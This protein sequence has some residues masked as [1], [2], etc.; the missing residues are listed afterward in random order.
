MV[1]VIWVLENIKRDN[2]FYK[3]FNT[4]LLFN[5]VIQWR[6]HN[7]NTNTVLLCDELTYEFLTKLNALNLW[8]E[9]KKMPWIKDIDKDVFWA[10]AKV[11][12]ISGIEAPSV[13]LDNDFIVYSNFEKYLGDK[14]IVGHDEDGKNYYPNAMDEYVRQTRE[15]LNRPNHKSINCCFLYFPNPKFG[16]NYGLTSLELMKKLTEIKAP[17]SK[18]LVYAEQL[19][20]KHLLDLHK[21]EYIPLIGDIWHCSDRKWEKREEGIIKDKHPQLLFRH[22][23]MEKNKILSNEEGYSYDNEMTELLRVIVNNTDIDRTDITRLPK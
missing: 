18:Y 14:I 3:Q 16:K 9:V 4:A 15:Y 13:I 11:Q 17:N 12:G 21:Q 7:K 23:W 6:K 19:L 8:H 10:S 2:S 20:L 5:S 1:N 22:Y